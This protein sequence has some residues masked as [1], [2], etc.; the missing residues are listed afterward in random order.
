MAPVLFESSIGVLS[1]CKDK[2]NINAFLPE[3]G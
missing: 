1:F 2:I 3:N